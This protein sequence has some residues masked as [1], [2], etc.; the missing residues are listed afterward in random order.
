MTRGNNTGIDG[1][2]IDA[3]AQHVHRF[4]VYPGVGTGSAGELAYLSLG[5]CGEAGEVAEKIK[6][7]IRDGELDPVALSKEFGDVFWYLTQLCRAMGV[8]P[9]EV[10]VGNAQKL[11]Q[12]EVR[13]TLKGSG[14]D[15]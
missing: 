13:G 9:S 6:K 3:Y 14:D 1:K 2:D 10:L 15:R 5:L 12:R 4:A 11:T 7:F 8:T